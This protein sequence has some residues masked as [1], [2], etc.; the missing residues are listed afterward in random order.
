MCSKVR[1]RWPSQV[2]NLS[3]YDIVCKANY[4]RVHSK[5]EGNS[6]YKHGELCEPQYCLCGN[7]KDFRANKCV[8]CR[9][10]T[11][12][13]IPVFFSIGGKPRNA[14]LWRYIKSFNL[15]PHDKCLFC[16]QLPYHNG[17]ILSLHL[18]HIN[19]IREDNRIENLRVLC[20]NCHTQTDTYASKNR[21]FNK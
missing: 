5:G 17:K 12:Q 19:G 16:G 15:L 14:T 9:R 21:R 1:L 18:D 7:E 3:F 2:R 13:N 6:N 20:P 8:T 10:D 4:M 11:V